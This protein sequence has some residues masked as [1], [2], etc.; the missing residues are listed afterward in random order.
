MSYDPL[1]QSSDWLYHLGDVTDTE[2]NTVANSGADMVVIEFARYNDGEVPY[3]ASDLTAMRG[4]D[5]KL[6][7]SYMSIGEAESY[8][9]Y[10]N[11]PEFQNI[12]ERIIAEEN[13]EWEENFKIRYWDKDWQKIIFDYVDRIIE[14]GFDGLYLDIVDAYYYWED[15]DPSGAI[16]YRKE[17]ADFVAAIRT[18]I[19]DQLSHVKREYPFYIIGQ[20]GEELIANDV[21]LNAIDGIGREDVQFYYDNTTPENFELLNASE[22]NNTISLLEQATAAGKKV[23]VVEYLDKVRQ[24]EYNTTLDAL[25]NRLWDKGI[26]VYIAENRSLDAVFKQ[27][28]T[29]QFTRLISGTNDGETLRGKIYGDVIDAGAGNDIVWAG[30]GDTGNDIIIG[31]AG[32]DMMGGSAGNDLLVGGGASDGTNIHILKQ[33]SSSVSSGSDTLF[34]GAGN[35][36]LIGDN[37]RDGSIQDNGAFDIG[38]QTQSGTAKNTIWSGAGH[39]L[40]Y[41]AAGDDLIGGSAGDDTIHSGNGADTLFGSAN[42]DILYGEAGTDTIFNGGGNDWVDGGTGDD[43]LYGGPDNDTIWGGAGKDLFSFTGNS[44][45]DVIK[46]FNLTDD[47]LGLSGIETF[48]TIAE[49][50]TA[51][52]EFVKDGQSGLLITFGNHSIFIVGLELTQFDSIEIIL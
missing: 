12:S 40:I 49:V 27:P 48:S 19:D 37:W 23:F 11:T 7:I 34:G 5:N 42:N 3:S 31:G 33:D 28:T 44:G 18:H 32:N 10:W 36:T 30:N 26:P 8:R 41:G 13:P 2:I 35:D 20:N 6:I 43:T 14:A 4:T 9:F 15:R 29:V 22:V 21:Y 25:T 16:D 46:D 51:T 17:M 45:E 52:L 50:K 38:E 39:D 24:T 47:T 1:L